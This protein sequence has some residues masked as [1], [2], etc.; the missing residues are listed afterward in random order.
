MHAREVIQQGIV[1]FDATHSRRTRMRQ[2][3][4]LNAPLNESPRGEKPH[5]T[6]AGS[7]PVPGSPTSKPSPNVSSLPVGDTSNGLLI[8]SWKQRVIP[9]HN[10][11]GTLSGPASTHAVL[12]SPKSPMVSADSVDSASKESM[13]N[14][15]PSAPNLERFLVQFVVEQTGYPVEIVELDADLEADLGI[16]SI[17]KAQMFGEINEYFDLDL[18]N[19]QGVSLDDFG[20]LRSIIRFLSPLVG[21]LDS[22]QS[23]LSP[24]TFPIKHA[25]T[26]SGT[27]DIGGFITDTNAS[28]TNTVVSGA[29]RETRASLERFLVQFVVEQTGYPE[30]IVEL[31]A[32]LEADLGIDSIKKA[33]MF[34]EINEYFDLDLSTIQGLS[35]D[36]FNSL[37][38]I[39]EFLMPVVKTENNDPMATTISH[40]AMDSTDFLNPSTQS[41]KP[42]LRDFLIRFVIEQ[43][44]YPEEIVEL[45]SD[46][47]AD[48]GIDSIKKAQLL[49]EVNEYFDLGLS[50][51]GKVSLDDFKT[52]RDILQ[53]VTQSTV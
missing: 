1:H 11:N 24:A 32:D 50:A 31:D 14:S 20:T 15:K 18:S 33:Q 17:K 45:D 44:G 43:T 19:I 3:A 4:S 52:L 46:L 16:D 51:N 7:E 48:L 22:S 39:V 12:A 40:S 30:E 27:R 23:S 25:D 37:R 21:G 10:D 35:L 13:V 41:S 8:H 29:T 28:N 6:A 9:G 47:E 2:S 5:D 53:F 49:G 38:S 26:T 36:D 34:G 42:M